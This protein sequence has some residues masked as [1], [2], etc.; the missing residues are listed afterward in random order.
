M[1]GM[2]E[3]S[4]DALRRALD[5]LDGV[6]NLAKACD[7]SVQAVYKWLENGVTAERAIEIETATGGKVTRH[8]LRPDLYPV[9]SSVLSPQSSDAERVA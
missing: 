9:Q 6:R 5:I 4:Q 8:E 2:S 7:V 1:A 3:T